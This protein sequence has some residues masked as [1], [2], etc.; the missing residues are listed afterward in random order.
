MGNTI[1]DKTR[2]WF[3]MKDNSGAFNYTGWTDGRRVRLLWEILMLEDNAEE[4]EMF[5]ILE[6]LLRTLN[7]EYSKTSKPT[8]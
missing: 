5:R 8:S 7:T 1:R 4:N 6:E 3:T 2:Y